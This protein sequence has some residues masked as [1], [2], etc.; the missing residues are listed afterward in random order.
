MAA[1]EKATMSVVCPRA[2]EGGSPRR[3]D[4]PATGVGGH[5]QANAQPQQLLLV[6]SPGLT[7]RAGKPSPAE[8]LLYP[9]SRYQPGQSLMRPRG[10]PCEVQQLRQLDLRH[11]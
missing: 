1:S 10:I 2:A 8:A 4:G 3:V 6:H 11:E 9:L 5:N 7:E